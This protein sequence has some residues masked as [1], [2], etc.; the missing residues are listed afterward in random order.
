VGGLRRRLYDLREPQHV[1][2]Q[3][4]LKQSTGKLRS[5]VVRVQ[6]QPTN[7]IRGS[8]GQQRYFHQ[9]VAACSRQ[10]N[11]TT[12]ATHARRTRPPTSAMQC[13]ASDANTCP[14][15]YVVRLSGPLASPM[16][17]AEG[18]LLPEDDLLRELG[19]VTY[20]WPRLGGL[21]EK[22]PEVLAAEVLP[23]LGP[24]DLALF[25]RVGQA[26]RAAVLASGLPRAGTEGGGPL[27]LAELCGS[28]ERLAW[29]KANGCPW[30]ARTCEIAA[31]CTER[32][33]VL[34]WAREHGCDWD[35]WTCAR[36]ATGGHLEVL[37]W[38]REHGCP[39]MEVNAD[40]AELTMNCC[41]CAAYGGHLEVL[42][43]LREQDCPWGMRTCACAAHAGHLEVLKW[44]REHHC[45]WDH[46][47]RQFAEEE[48]HLEL[49]QWAVEHGA[50]A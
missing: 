2:S 47:T 23:W 21:L 49:L 46:R 17:R 4:P 36:A 33:E 11:T 19:L 25:A 39:W 18:A 5:R 22:L 10:A 40:N 6:V 26:S 48:G 50:P 31:H 15:R 13:P 3:L 27:K 1:E 8:E 37:K 45:P 30:V 20:P 9:R 24:T 42:K 32:V 44:V 7:V 12:R 29:A 16:G 38:A 14:D 41:V 34:R 43:W 28:V 35:E